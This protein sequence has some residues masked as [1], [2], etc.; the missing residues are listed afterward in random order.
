MNVNIRGVGELCLRAT[1]E[2]L[3]MSSNPSPQMGLS[4]KSSWVEVQENMRETSIL[5]RRQ[6]RADG[7]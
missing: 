2:E 3:T 6:G 1:D 4:L 7:H 5:R